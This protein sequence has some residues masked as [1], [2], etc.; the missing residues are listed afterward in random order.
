MLDES[1]SDHQDYLFNYYHE[2]AGLKEL[3]EALKN[4]L[5]SDDIYVIQIKLSLLQEANRLS[6][7]YHRWISVMVLTKFFWNN[8]PTTV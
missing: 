7:S 1:L 3:V 4:R 5:A 6:I 8:L 2:Q